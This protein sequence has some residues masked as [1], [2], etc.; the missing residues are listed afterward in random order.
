METEKEINSKILKKIKEIQEKHPELTE[1][2]NEMP[3]TIPDENS[4]EINAKILKDY[5]DTLNQMLKNQDA[6]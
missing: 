6:K 2:F 1:F 4:P 5:Y 3:N